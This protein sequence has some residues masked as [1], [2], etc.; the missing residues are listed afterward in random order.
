MTEG[1]TIMTVASSGLAVIKEH[2]LTDHM[3]EPGKGQSGSVTEHSEAITCKPTE[4]AWGQEEGNPLSVQYD[5]AH[6]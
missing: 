6:K 1:A 3:S 4:V 5:W 2:R